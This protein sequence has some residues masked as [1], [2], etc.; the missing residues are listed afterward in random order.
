MRKNNQLRLP[1]TKYGEFRIKIVLRVLLL[2]IETKE[3]YISLLSLK[4]WIFKIIEVFSVKCMQALNH[5]LAAICLTELQ[6]STLPQ[7]AKQTELHHSA[8]NR[9]TKCVTFFDI[10]IGS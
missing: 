2:L 9:L 6:T 3:K 7:T 8:D 4:V 10:P 5:Q 1:S